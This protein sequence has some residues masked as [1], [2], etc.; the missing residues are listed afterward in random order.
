MQGGPRQAAWHGA[1]TELVHALRCDEPLPVTQLRA[2]LRGL[3]AEP[4]PGTWH[5]TGFIVVRVLTDEQGALRLHL[6]PTA[7]RE[8]GQ[9][10]WPV[11][12]HVWSLRS[13]VLCGTVHSH[14]YDVDDD[15]AGDRTLYA[16]EYGAD[17]RSCMHRG[18]RGVRLS[19]RV[20]ERIEAGQRYEVQAGSFHASQVPAGAMAA[21][22]V[23]TTVT[24]RAHPRVVGPRHGPSVVPVVRPRAE[25]NL[26]LGLLEQ[27]AAGLRSTP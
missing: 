22:L 7:S 17:D 16:V 10:C 3:S 4:P 12:D 23:A 27:V 26:M 5:P 18:D 14:G 11:H 15:A 6:W 1:A 20:P 25:P 8:Q 9:P 19:A 24:D 13:H 21:T 2:L